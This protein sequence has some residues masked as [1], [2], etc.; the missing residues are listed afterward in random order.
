MHWSPPTVQREA[1]L[2]NLGLPEADDHQ[3]LKKLIN[4][5]FVNWTKQ[6]EVTCGRRPSNPDHRPLTRAEGHQ[7]KLK[8]RVPLFHLQ[9][10]PSPKMES[11]LL[12]SSGGKGPR[13][14]TNKCPSCP[15]P[16]SSTGD[17]LKPPTR[18][19]PVPR[20]PHF[21]VQ[22]IAIGWGG[23]VLPIDPWLG[24][25]WGP[26]RGGGA[27][28]GPRQVPRPVSLLSRECNRTYFIPS[29]VGPSLPSFS[30]CISISICAH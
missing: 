10:T 4:R 15:L 14:H 12:G 3:S 16:R 26:T 23:V 20:L 27:G 19:P 17:N 21:S 28:Q 25:G 6:W 5:E 9:A 8:L 1:S 22:A 2:V 7:A 11:A 13:H 29:F 30:T 18:S 24:P